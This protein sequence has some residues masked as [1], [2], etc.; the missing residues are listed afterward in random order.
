M[1]GK[2]VGQTPRWVVLK[3]SGGFSLPMNPEEHPTSN[4][5]RPNI[6]WQRESSPTSE[7]GFRCWT[8]DVFPRFCTPRHTGFA[9]SS[10]DP[11]LARKVLL[12]NSENARRLTLGNDN[13]VTKDLRGDADSEK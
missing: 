6:E 3:A 9:Q 11:T 7:F 12:N 8:F 5:Q 13:S 1:F 10:F 4:I 2:F